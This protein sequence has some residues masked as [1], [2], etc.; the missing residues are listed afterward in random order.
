MGDVSPRVKT[1]R[2]LLAECVWVPSKA[3]L[4]LIGICAFAF[5]IIS[6]DVGPTPLFLIYIPFWAIFACVGFY[7][8]MEREY[9]D[10]ADEIPHNQLLTFSSYSPTT[11]RYA[12]RSPVTENVS[13]RLCSHCRELLLKSGLLWGSSTWITHAEETYAFDC[14]NRS[15]L[16]TAITCADCE[17]CRL[18]RSALRPAYHDFNS[19][20][21]T[22]ST[23]DLVASNR[24]YGTINPTGRYISEELKPRLKIFEVE[25]E[26]GRTYI[27]LSVPGSLSPAFIVHHRQ[28]SAS[29]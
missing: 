21:L 29:V 9:Q 26:E 19:C 22:N 17:L 13:S 10:G 5:V 20:N 28:L 8:D 3:L 2:R 11:K 4:F 24:G 7:K 15:P 12:I 25:G 16:D 18:L 1:K 23:A 27:Q 14:Y 6:V